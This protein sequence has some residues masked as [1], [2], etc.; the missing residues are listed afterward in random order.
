MLR[1]EGLHIRSGGFGLPVSLMLQEHLKHL[2]AVTSQAVCACAAFFRKL[3]RVTQVSEILLH[4]R[5]HPLPHRHRWKV[6]PT[7]AF[8]CEKS[9]VPSANGPHLCDMASPLRNLHLRIPVFHISRKPSV[10]ESAK[11]QL[12]ESLGTKQR[13]KLHGHIPAISLSRN[14]ND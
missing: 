8:Q 14:P 4:L 9:T 2:R 6:E 10:H 11:H 1:V 5:P 3:Y 7:H 13:S 12:S